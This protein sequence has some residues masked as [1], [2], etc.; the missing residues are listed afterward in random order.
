MGGRGRGNQVMQPVNNLKYFC[1]ET[2]ILCK[3]QTL[4][5]F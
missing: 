5:E 4:Y 3:R 2:N 1:T